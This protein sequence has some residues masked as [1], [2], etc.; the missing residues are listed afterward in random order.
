[1]ARAA[2][3]PR[4]EFS[5]A[6]PRAVPQGLHE[7]PE[8]YAC[9]T[10]ARAE[11]KVDRLLGER[12][13]ESYLPLVERTRQWSDRTK[14]VEFPLL[15]GY[16]FARFPLNTLHEVFCTPGLVHVV[17]VNGY[18]TP[19]REGELES[20]RA[21]VDGASRAG[22]EPMP[23]DGLLRGQDVWVVGGPLEGVRGILVEL[24]GRTRV[25]VRIAA[26]RQAVSVEVDRSQVRP[27]DDVEKSSLR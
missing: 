2:S 21:L 10:R 5:F 11:K 17:Q 19:V 16:V 18:P 20:I 13:I 22:L 27:I 8:W 3:V 4:G 7:R 12:R 1:M 14:R 25:V 15:P 6:P 24:R 26:I 23:H 9:R